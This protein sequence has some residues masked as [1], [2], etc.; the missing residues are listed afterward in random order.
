MRLRFASF[1]I[2]ACLLVVA[3]HGAAVHALSHLSEP[4]ASS[5]SDNDQDGAKHLP[6]CDKCVGYASVG[7]ALH[8]AALVIHAANLLLL[9]PDAAS[10]PAHLPSPYQLHPS[11][12]PPAFL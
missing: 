3:Q 10:D 8:T 11:R 12:A 2:L 1:L 9:L 6:A 7:A 5:T 4:P